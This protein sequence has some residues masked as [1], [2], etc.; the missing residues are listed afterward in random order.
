M[1]REKAQ[2]SSRGY[3]Y[4]MLGCL[5]LRAR[6]SLAHL[7]SNDAAHQQLSRSAATCENAFGCIMENIGRNN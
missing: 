2:M 5:G 7:G 4:C 6:G 3:K 1:A